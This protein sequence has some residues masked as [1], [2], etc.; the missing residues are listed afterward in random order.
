MK[1]KRREGGFTLME[2]LVV[3]II[4]GVLAAIGIPTYLNQVEKARARQAY[5]MLGAYRE[6]EVRFYVASATNAYTATLANL[7]VQGPAGGRIYWTFGAVAA[8]TG[9][10]ATFTITATRSEGAHATE[11]I[12]LNQAGTWGGTYTEVVPQN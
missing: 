10:G 12:T 3:L 5:E 7:D 2:L 9:A 11:T 8:G 6:A 1:R 4:I